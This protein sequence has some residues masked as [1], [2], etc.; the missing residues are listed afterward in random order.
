VTFTPCLTSFIFQQYK[1]G[2]R[3]ELNNT[4]DI[5]TSQKRSRNC[6]CISVMAVIEGTIIYGR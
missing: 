3:D 2:F 6:V 1:N 4:R 5:V